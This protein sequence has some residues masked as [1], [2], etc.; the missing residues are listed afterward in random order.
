MDIV[1][2]ILAYLGCMAGVVGALLI[3][4]SV[5]FSAPNVPQRVAGAN[6]QTAA[7]AAK[8]A[9]P[10]PAIAAAKIPAQQS[11]RGA[12]VVSTIAQNTTPQNTT[13]QKTTAAPAP[14]VSAHSKVVAARAQKM[15]RFVQEERARRWAYQ[16]DPD[17]EARFLGYAD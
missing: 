16:Q 4:F 13:S 12:S 6:G 1:A 7:T 9:T 5:F 11:G 10:K 8:T 15:R 2:S 17:F 14:S 3:S